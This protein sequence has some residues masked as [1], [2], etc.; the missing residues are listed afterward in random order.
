[1]IRVKISNRLYIPLAVLPM[2]LEELLKVACEHKNPKYYK[3][4]GMGFRYT[5]EPK[6]IKTW[7]I[8]G[9]T[10]SL[11]RGRTD[12]VRQ[13]FKQ[14]SAEFEFNDQRED[15]LKENK[16]ITQTSILQMWDHQEEVIAAALETQNCLI[17][18]PTGSGKTSAALEF[19]VRTQLPT[20]VIVWSGN[21]FDQWI[22][23]ICKEL[24]M[25]Q[26]QIGQIRG[27]KHTIAPITMAMQ[28][29]LNAN[30]ELVKE[31]RT[32]FGVLVLDEVQR[33][34]AKTVSQVVDAFPA[35]YR[36]GWS[37]DFRRK[38]GLDFL[39][40]DIF[41][42]VAATIDRNQ[43]ISKQLVLDV[44]VI[45]IPTEFTAEWYTA[46]Q[47][48]DKHADYGRLLESMVDDKDRTSL[49]TKVV[50]YELSLGNQVLMLTH[51]RNLVNKLVELTRLTGYECGAMV[52]G[53]SGSA[54]LNDAVQRMRAETLRAAAG[55]YQAI[56][57]GLDIP[58][59]SRGI[60]CTPIA[61][62]K[63]LF[64]QVRGRLCRIAP[65]KENAILYYLWDQHVFGLKPLENLKAWNRDVVV[66][67]QS[68][69][70]DI[71]IFL[72]SEQKNSLR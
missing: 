9:N 46:Q 1:M 38:D 63:Q 35:I 17:Q 23:R 14:F 39:T 65:G 16:A 20:L 10:L 71:K 43:L 11:P 51:R 57:Q 37:A 68:G 56:G 27:K 24:K 64:G 22:E 48:S 21:L 49:I 61:T 30:P 8:K 54:E 29:T 32:K 2:G 66:Q 45:V 41:G 44:K 6:T 5:Q 36:V 34:A 67:T 3:A 52:G 50:Q 40:N 26:N 59:V 58:T 60:A 4:V 33:C 53:P 19:A 70:I 28:Q 25:D 55:T 47:G 69:L 7:R 15:G 13:S 62:N 18:S 12:V 31:I 42:Q 72:A